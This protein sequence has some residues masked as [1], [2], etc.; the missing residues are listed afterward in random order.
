MKFGS[1][2]PVLV[3]K[4]GG[5]KNSDKILAS[6][7]RSKFLTKKIEKFSPDLVIS[8]C[9]PEAS[10]VAYGLNIPHIAFSDSP[11]AKAVM[12]L[13][14]PFVTKLLTPWII[15]KNDFTVFGINSKNII[16]YRSIDAALIIKNYKKIKIKKSKS[17]KIILIRPEEVEAA[18]ASKSSNT[19]KIIK[20]IVK[21]F[22]DEEKIVLSRYKNQSKEMKKIF[23]SQISLFSKPING[24]AILRRVDCFVGSGGTMTAEA[25]LL[26][27][28]TISL[29]SIPNRIEDYMVKK[30]LIVRA[31]TPE[32][33]SKEISDALTSVNIRKNH[34]KKIVS[35]FEDP[36]K[37]LLKTI[38]T[39]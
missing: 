35:K 11:H 3:G 2:T 29:N 16:R 6:L 39:L 28:P 23:G 34:A 30:R 15:P 25:G 20:K 18:Y 19:I 13:S 7:K 5:R 36:Y 21:D 12:K 1:T 8:F 31:N 33:V 38:K 26:G 27:I 37:I 17:K 22:P 14:L 4:H 24:E 10:R 9:S 32:K